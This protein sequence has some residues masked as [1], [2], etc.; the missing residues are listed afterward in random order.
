MS[1]NRSIDGKDLMIFI[2]G[3]AIALATSH[4]VS[5]TADTSNSAS[6]DDGI[7]KRN[8]VT[9]LGWEMYFE[10]LVSADPSKN[11]YGKLKKAMK[12]RKEVDVISGVPANITD[13]G[14]PEGGWTV[15]TTNYQKGKAVITSIERNDPNDGDSTMSGTL[16]GNGELQDVEA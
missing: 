4:R 13:S 15:P 2:D 8:R 7:W 14:M 16:L 10:A 9:K 5:L 3:E 12:E 6:K 1:D 11:S